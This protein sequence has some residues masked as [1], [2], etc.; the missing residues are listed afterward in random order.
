MTD[1]LLLCTANVCRSVMA[2]ALL[3]RRLHDRRVAASVRSAGMLDAGEPA[4]PGAVRAL[5]DRGIDVSA[6]RSRQVGDR[7]L[8]GA[9]LVVAMAR[10]HLRH[11]VVLAPQVWPRAF[12]LK[13]LVRRGQICGPRRTHQPLA[14]WLAQLHEGRERLGLLGDCQSDDVADPIGGPPGA[15]VATAALLDDLLERLADLAWGC[16]SPR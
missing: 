2:Q 11:A 16:E 6:H 13:E 14:Q 8:I 10:E 12:T 1:I 7:D 5:A 3:S 4:A 15:Y 9:D